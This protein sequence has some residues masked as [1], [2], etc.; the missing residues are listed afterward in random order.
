MSKKD[1][2]IIADF[3]SGFNGKSNN[4]FIYLA[5]NLIKKEYNVEIIT[6]DFFHGEKKPFNPLVNEYNGIKVTM[7]HEPSYPTNVCVK[8]FFSHYKWGKNVYK[9]LKERK[10]PDVVYSAMP[11]LKAASLAGKYCNK[12]G[13]KFIIDVQDLWPEAYMLVFNIPFISSIIFYP[14]KRIANSAYK[15]ADEI[16]AV[17]QTYVNRAIKVNKKVKEG[18]SVF[19]GTD[20]KTFDENVRNAKLIEKKQ[21]EIW[22]GY[23]GTL[24]AS[25][26]ISIVFEAMRIY[27][28]PKLKFIIMGNGPRK[29]EFIDNSKGLNV[30]FLGTVPYQDMCGI[31]C[32]CDIVVNPIMH[33]AAQSIINKHADYAASGLPVINTQENK[34]YKDL[35]EK[36]NMG[37]NVSNDDVKDLVNKLKLLCDNPNL[38]KEKGENARKCAHDLFDRGNSYKTII[39]TIN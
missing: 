36:Y 14:F 34:E 39:K 10:K 21:D 31:L 5:E 33:N 38:R 23:C 30:Q 26:N 3:C 13:I 24:G 8:R 32:E 22:L 27:N 25:Y 4:R 18:H 20:L 28:N 11:T 9:Y 29:Q 16:I 1:I 35:V 2:V 15:R 7:L 19:L 6:S 17:S 12:N 37:F